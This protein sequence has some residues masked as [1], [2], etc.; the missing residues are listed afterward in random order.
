MNQQRKKIIKIRDF[1]NITDTDGLKDVYEDLILANK[2]IEDKQ[3][4]NFNE[5]FVYDLDKVN[6]F[7]FL[8]L[9]IFRYEIFSWK[10]SAKYKK[11]KNMFFPPSSEWFNVRKKAKEKI[12]NYFRKLKI[13]ENDKY[14]NNYIKKFLL[15]EFDDYFTFIESFQSY[16]KKN[17]IKKIKLLK[18]Y[19]LFDNI[20]SDEIKNKDS[21]LFIFKFL[22]AFIFKFTNFI[23][24]YFISLFNNK[25]KIPNI[26]YLRKKIYP[27]PYYSNLIENNINSNIDSTFIAFSPNKKKFDINYLNN[28][29]IHL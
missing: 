9:K 21:S 20:L 15:L 5:A 17:N 4:I 22:I 1:V 26:L 27:C 10:Q 25:I 28:F 3:K 6:I 14:I 7:K 13:K 8:F 23:Y 24:Y 19:K 29:K 16:K 2:N 11:S 12:N 18:Y